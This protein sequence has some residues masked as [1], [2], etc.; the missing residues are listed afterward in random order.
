MNV[1]LKKENGNL[2]QFNSI[3]LSFQNYCISNLCWNEQSVMTIGT[4]GALC[5]TLYACVRVPND[6]HSKRKWLIEHLIDNEREEIN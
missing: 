5:A 1:E 3:R 6:K 2:I 4:F